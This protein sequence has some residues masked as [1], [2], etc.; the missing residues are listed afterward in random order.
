MNL[1]SYLCFHHVHSDKNHGNEKK[2]ARYPEQK[3][4]PLVHTLS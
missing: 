2:Q 4:A 3:T 1:K